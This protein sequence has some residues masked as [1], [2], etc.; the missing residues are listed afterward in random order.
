MEHTIRF[1]MRMRVS[2]LAYSFEV[3]LAINITEKNQ[4]GSN[5]RI[6]GFN[7]NTLLLW[8]QRNL[9][10]CFSPFEQAVKFI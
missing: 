8:E 3:G 5:S 9:V 10:I 2:A 6:D 1:L 4:I 7:M